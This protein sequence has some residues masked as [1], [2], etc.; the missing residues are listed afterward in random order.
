MLPKRW[1]EHAERGELLAVD[2]WRRANAA[3]W[4][5]PGTPEGPKRGVGRSRQGRRSWVR[6][7]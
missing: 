6:L 7:H 2:G 3:P 1:A 5:T 4:P